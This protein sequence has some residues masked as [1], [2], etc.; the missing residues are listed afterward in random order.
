MSVL[1]HQKGYS[2]V[3]VLV[4]TAI[5]LIATVGPLTIAAKGIQTAQFAR[6][7]ATATFLAQEGVEAVVALRNS[8][9]IQ[10]LDDGDLSTS[11]DWQTGTPGIDRCFPA[12]GI[13][14]GCNMDF[15][16]ANV[17]NPI[18]ACNAPANCA[19]RYDV[20][21]N[22]PYTANGSGAASPYMRVITLENTGPKEVRITSTVYWD[23]SLY[24]G[25]TLEQV[26]FSSTVFSL[27][28]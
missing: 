21:T 28:E 4:A 14:N 22:I 10:A 19:L 26:A 23:S 27:Y 15:N 20:T 6:E 18:R 25:G 24:R 12:R 13:S 8:S 9:I 3:E 2:L 7:Q 17:A 1:H 16:N 5:L 11:W